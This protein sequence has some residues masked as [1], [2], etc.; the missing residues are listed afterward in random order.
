MFSDD[1]DVSP[2]RLDDLNHRDSSTEHRASAELTR[3]V[4]LKLDI[5][6]VIIY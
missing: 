4:L 2:D 6:Y 3:R 1:K 5:R